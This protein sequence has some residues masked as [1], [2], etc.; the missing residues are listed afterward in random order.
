M[1]MCSN[2]LVF[3]CHDELSTKAEYK[4]TC[5]CLLKVDEPNYILTGNYL[6]RQRTIVRNP[7]S[8]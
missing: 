3:H 6:N 8:L 5:K 7:L 2:S 1:N 4:N